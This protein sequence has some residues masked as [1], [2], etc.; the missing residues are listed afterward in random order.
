MRLSEKMRDFLRFSSTNTR[1]SSEADWSRRDFLALSSVVAAAA[2]RLGAQ[3]RKGKGKGP[4]PPERE[5]YMIHP[6]VGVARIGN[7]PHSFFPEPQT[8]GGLP[9]E[10]DSNG[11]PKM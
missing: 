7:S 4:G 10:C 3:P 6:A 1:A 11:N 8:I 2:T 5:S 9:I